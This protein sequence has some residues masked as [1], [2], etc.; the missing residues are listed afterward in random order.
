MKL[1][2]LKIYAIAMQL[3]E[4]VWEIVLKWDYFSKRYCRKT[5]G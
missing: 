2:D 5:M 3:G 1:E 4:E